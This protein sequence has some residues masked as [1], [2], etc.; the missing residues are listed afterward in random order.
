VAETI[1]ES[2]M[3]DGYERIITGLRAAARVSAGARR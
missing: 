2:D 1:T 3:V